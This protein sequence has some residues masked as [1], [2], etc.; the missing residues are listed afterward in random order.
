MQIINGAKGRTKNRI[1]LICIS[2]VPVFILL[3]GY[4]LLTHAYGYSL[5]SL[6]GI[7]LCMETRV[8]MG[9]RGPRKTAFAMHMAC[10][11][12]LIASLILLSTLHLLPWVLVWVV[13]I[14]YFAFLGM[15]VTGIVLIKQSWHPVY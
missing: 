6:L 3:S 13:P 11:A 7:V 12:A 10:N 9:Y 4:F 1:H 8:R 5:I 15:V 14:A 2:L